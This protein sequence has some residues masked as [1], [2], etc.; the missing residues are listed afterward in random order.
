MHG[1]FSIER[2]CREPSGPD[3]ARRCGQRA[4]SQSI[5]APRAR[6]IPLEPGH[7]SGRLGHRGESAQRP[8]AGAVRCLDPGIA[9][10]VSRRPAGCECAFK[11][12]AGHAGS[13]VAGNAG[14]ATLRGYIKR[15]ALAAIGFYRAAISPALPS[16][17]RFYPTCSTYAYE[18]VSTWGLRRGL[19]LT[20]R[21]LG[22]C[23]PFGPFGYDPVPEVSGEWQVASDKHAGS[24]ARH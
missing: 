18:A 4:A 11:R 1:V 12:G 19:G 9:A 20:L 17:C 15:L 14:A 2:T 6:S 8:G 5:E 24:D 23:R 10:A 3:G 13:E 22:R 21:R 7:D 16:S